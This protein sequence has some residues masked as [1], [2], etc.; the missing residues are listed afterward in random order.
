MKFCDELN[1]YLKLL[2]CSPKEFS[3]ITGFSPTII[4]RYL[5]DKRTPRIDSEYFN[6]IVN[7][8]FELAKIKNIDLNKEELTNTLT[9][10][11]TSNNINYDIFVNNFNTLISE[12]KINISDLA[13]SIGYDTS[14]ISK[15]KNKNRKPYDI[16][17]FIDLITEY[18][19]DKFQNE[20]QMLSLTYLINCSTNDLKNTDNYKLII[21]DWLITSKSNNNELVQNFLT[22]LDNFNINDYINKDFEKIKIPTSP[23]ILK[24]SKILYGKDGRKKSEAEFLKTT[25]ISKSKEPIFF[26]NDLPITNAGNDEDFKQKWVLAMAMLLKK[27]LHLNMIHN[28]YRPLNE[29]FLGLENWIPIYMTGSISPYYFPTP[30]SNLFCT[31]QCTSGAV[32]LSGECSQNNEELGRFYV[33]TKKEDLEY[34]KKKSK[35][36]LS[37]AKPL[38]TIYKENDKDKFKDFMATINQNKIKKVEIDTFKNIDFCIYENKWVMINKNNTPKIHFVIYNT[39]LRTAIEAFIEKK[40]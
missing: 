6:K 29:M 39:K 34:Y 9:K 18:I 10:S 11:I 3:E 1:N 4:S 15:I 22:K 13:K 14:F 23:V 20:D 30:P 19:V 12:L 8:L 38:M 33:T 32:A 25:L 35:F 2:D 40:D 28:I 27:G 37:K 17:K 5:N 16:E 7:S 26:Y 24:T 36:L 21:K 31:S